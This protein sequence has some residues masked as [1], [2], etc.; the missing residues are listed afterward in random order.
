MPYCWKCGAK[1]D[2]DAKFCP[3]CGASMDQ[4]RIRATPQAAS[5]STPPRRRGLSPLHILVIVLGTILFLA[6]VAG[7]LVF[8]PIRQV[9]FS[10][11]PNQVPASPG[12]SALNL[13]IS[14]DFARLNI[15]FADL[16]GRLVEMNVSANG[17]AG[18]LVPS[19][20]VNVTLSYYQVGNTVVAS[21]QVSRVGVWWPFGGLNVIADVL[22]DP[23]LPL[24]LSAKTTT[25]RID[26]ISS[27]NVVFE[28]LTV[29]ATTGAVEAT[30]VRN[31]ILGGPVS[32]IS[33]TGS[34]DFFMNNVRLSTNIS[35]DARATTGSINVNIVQDN[36]T[37][38]NVTLHEEAVTGS[39]TFS[40][41]ISDSVGAYI[42]S[43]T[44]LG[45]INANTLGFS[46]NKTSLM[47]S[48][49]PAT[50]NFLA[51]LRT[52]VGGIDLNATY[53]PTGHL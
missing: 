39:V 26:F 31:T 7:V 10:A 45:G 46:G 42:N 53:E 20:P 29:E 15:S 14:A 49:Y 1:L 27:P 47:S 43:S 41:A 22:I 38:G 17:R 34:V 32:V 48:N 37:P 35:V 33:T 25:G 13:S 50:S 21:A 5:S 9:S 30:L 24:N 12:A 3:V 40:L 51:T 16:N 6:L 18:L 52:T 36:A 19:D 2:E 44:T 8:L 4:S 23:S 28:S 11:P